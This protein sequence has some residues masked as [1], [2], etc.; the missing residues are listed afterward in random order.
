MPYK[1]GSLFTNGEKYT[2]KIHTLVLGV[3]LG[4][5]ALG[6]APSAQAQSKMGGKM[7]TPKKNIVQIA[8]TTPGFKTLV[9]AVTAAGLA[10]TLSGKGPFTVFAPTDAAFAKLP[11]GTLAK[12][13]KPA[14]K[15]T[16]VKIL[17]YHVVAKKAPAKVVLAMAPT[18]AVPTVQG[19]KVMVMHRGG[20]VT[21]M[22]GK[23]AKKVNVIKADIMA[24]NGVIH[25]IDNVLIP[26][27]VM[28][29]MK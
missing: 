23:G 12:L 13:L 11:K 9:K 20:K 26:P 15:G 8:A 1:S 10:P 3:A 18:T 2:M 28:R 5:L 14:N 17:T 6:V 27:S 22:A 24:S 7:M 29:A 4:S 21:L 19:E 16:L 25:V